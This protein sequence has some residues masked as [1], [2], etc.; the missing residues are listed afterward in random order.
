MNSNAT[1]KT[2]TGPK[3]VRTQEPEEEQDI[4]KARLSSTPSSPTKAAKNSLEL[5]VASLP[6]SLQPLILH[7]GNQIITGRCKRYPKKSIMQRMEDDAKYIPRSA[8]ATDFKITLSDCE[9]QDKERVSFLEQQIQQ[10]KDSYESSLKSVIEECIA[11]EIQA[12]KKEESQ[13]IMDLFPA[14]GKA[15]QQLQ[16]TNCDAHLQTVNALKMTP[17]LLEYGPI[18]NIINI[19]H[20]YRNHHTLDEVPKATIRTMDSEYATVAEQIKALQ[21]HTA[22]LQRPENSGT[23]LFI[24]CL[25]GILI[26]PTAAYDKQ[27]DEN[28]RLLSVKKLS[29]EIIM[30]K[31]TEDT[32][33]ELDGEGAADFEQLQDLIR[34]ECDKRDRK[35]AQLEDKCNK[36]EQQVKNP[37]KNMPKRGRSPNHEEKQIK[38]KE[39]SKTTKESLKKHSRQQLWRQ[40]QTKPRKPRTSRRRKQRFQAKKYKQTSIAVTKQTKSES[41]QLFWQEKTTK[42]ATATKLIAQFGFVGDPTISKRHNASITLAKI[43]TW[44]YFSRPS[45]MAFH[46]FTKRHKPQKNLRS[47]LGLGLKFIPT[48]SLTNCWSRLKQSSYDRLFRSVHLRFHFGGKHPS[49]VTTTYDPKIYVHSTWTTPHWTIPPIALEERLTRFSSALSKLFKT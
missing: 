45:N 32:A 2:R 44:Y 19:L 16:G 34:K 33:M 48:P 30:G 39:H 7:F 41:A 24:K 13:L 40:K 4:Q 38:S 10:A 15:I 49:E 37:Q 21:Y 14:I 27:V 22:S 18:E 11:L 35:Y 31:T 23:Q 8:K 46:D 47:L 6:T 3:R 29:N 12:A 9:K 5:A 1:T 42:E 28:K 43:P 17:A 36:L 26:T 25:K 20:F